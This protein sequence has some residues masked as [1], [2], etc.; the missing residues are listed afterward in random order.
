MKPGLEIITSDGKRI[1]HLG[2][3]RT[4]ALQ[5]A[6]SPHTIPWSWIARI[7]DDVILRRTYA[8]IVAEWGA[9]PGPMVIIGGRR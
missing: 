6:L 8:Q 9:E 7:D 2:P 3:R 1:G 4:D 5:V